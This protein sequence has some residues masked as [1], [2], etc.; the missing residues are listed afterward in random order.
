MNDILKN[1]KM[2]LMDVDGVMT[3]GKIIYSSDGQELKE[4]DIQDGMA[5]SLARRAGLKTGIITGRTSE[6]VKRRAEEL[7]YDYVTQGNDKKL[8]SYNICLNQFKLSND[9]VCYIGDDLPDI[10][11]LL[12]VGFPVAVANARD[13]L[14]SFCQ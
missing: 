13:E 12:N 2:V 7:K 4:F 14:K 8:G 10:P 6:M 9:E 5:I 11:V 1:I 3:N